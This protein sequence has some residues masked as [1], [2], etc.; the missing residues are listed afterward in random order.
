M[1]YLGLD[2]GTTGAKALLVDRQGKRMGIGYAGY[3]LISD[4]ERIEQRADDWAECGAAAVRQAI[5]GMDPADIAAL[6]LSTQGA[7]MLALDAGNRPIGN[8]L[9]WMDGRAKQETNELA[10]L[11]ARIIYTVTPAGGLTRH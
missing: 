8:A 2:I 1:Y 6:A 9:T 10:E 3:K 4:G 7:S 5:G 11:W